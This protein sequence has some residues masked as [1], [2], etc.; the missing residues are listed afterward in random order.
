MIALDTNIIVRV[1]T[2][3]DA[4]QHAA[5]VEVMRSPQLFVSRTVLLETAWVLT[6]TYA[7]ER[8]I[9]GRALS[10]LVGYPNM[11]IEDRGSVLRALAWHSQGMDIADAFHLSS[12]RDVTHFATFDKKL[13]A[14]AARLPDAPTVRV[15]GSQER[16]AD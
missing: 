13:A 4:T 16:V 14:A 11:T 7:L 6:H 10:A 9:V 8:A 2:R 1:V 12:P 5:A 3:D 15:V